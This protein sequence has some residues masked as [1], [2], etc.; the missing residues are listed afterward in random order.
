MLAGDN[1]R[2]YLFEVLREVDVFRESF[3]RFEDAADSWLKSHHDPAP[4]GKLLREGT[5]S[6]REM[7]V[8]IEGMLSSYARIS[9]FFFPQGHSGKFAEDRGSEL[10]KKIGIEDDHPLS[11]RDLRNHWMHLDERLDE[12]VQAGKDVPIGYAFGLE[13][14]QASMDLENTFRLIDPGRPAVFILGREFDLKQLDGTVRHIDQQAALAI[15]DSER[16]GIAG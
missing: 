7:S 10:R 6:E 11:D 14:E 15:S 3:T 9:L 1:V 12:Q 2:H 16:I 5:R 4:S 13:H 8:A